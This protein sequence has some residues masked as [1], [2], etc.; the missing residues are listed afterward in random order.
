[1]PSILMPWPFYNICVFTFAVFFYRLDIFEANER[2]HIG[3]K[4][5]HIKNTYML[6]SFIDNFV[7]SLALVRTRIAGAVSIW[8]GHKLCSDFALAQFHN[9]L[10]LKSEIFQVKVILGPRS[11]LDYI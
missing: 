1:M 10:D 5:L 9:G 3:K 8:S 2:L 4:C 7:E 11:V 6:P